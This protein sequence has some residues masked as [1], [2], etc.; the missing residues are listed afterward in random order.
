MTAWVING[1]GLDVHNAEIS[2]SDDGIARTKFWLADIAGCK[3]TKKRLAS[4]A[5]RLADFVEYC[6]PD[7]NVMKNAKRFSHGR[8]TVDNSIDDKL[9]LI[10]I[11]A[12]S[13][14]QQRLPHNAL[15]DI[16]SCINGFGVHISRAVIQACHDCGTPISEESHVLRAEQHGP[17]L[18]KVWGTDS[19]GGQLDQTRAM[20]LIYTMSLLFG[21]SSTTGSTTVPRY[22][23]Y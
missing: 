11:F 13:Q 18:Y 6:T 12:P 4:V 5:D 23:L 22:E 7:E 15:L 20:A 10:T 21:D 1:L 8:V 2:V 3:L 17:R 14:R 19:S 16:A 9:S